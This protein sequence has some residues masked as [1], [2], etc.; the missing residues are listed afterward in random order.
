MESEYVVDDIPLTLYRN[1]DSYDLQ[2]E[3]LSKHELIYGLLKFKTSELPTSEQEKV[4]KLQDQIISVYHRINQGETSNVPTGAISNPSKIVKQSFFPT[5]KQ[6]QKKK[7]PS[8]VRVS[9]QHGEILQ[10]ALETGA[11]EVMNV[12]MGDDHQY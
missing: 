4:I 9:N 3:M 11:E 2:N 10:K 8:L 7:T 6:S 5:R 12:H 1:T